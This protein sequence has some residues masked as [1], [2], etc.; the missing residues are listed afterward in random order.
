MSRLIS[1]FEVRPIQ[2]QTD[3]T[4]FAP[5]RGG[6]AAG[7]GD[8]KEKGQAKVYLDLIV[9]MI[10]AEVVTVYTFAIKLVPMIAQKSAESKT[11]IGTVTTG[12]TTLQVV[13]AWCLFVVS[14]ILTPIALWLEQDEP[15]GPNWN[16]T[17]K[18]R[19]ILATL[20]FPLWAYAT[21]GEYLPGLSYNNALALILIAVYAVVA[22]I[23][24]RLVAPKKTA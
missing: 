20:A 12:W 10:P 9:K 23:I 21:S 1:R 8:A 15:P 18:V 13:V 6:L 17:V 3:A 16:R 11:V 4:T 14:L 7:E 24:A 2:K 19:L 22:G 5:E